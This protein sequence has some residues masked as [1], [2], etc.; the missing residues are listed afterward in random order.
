MQK[1]GTIPEHGAFTQLHTPNPP[2][3]KYS[4]SQNRN[5]KFTTKVNKA[6][7]GSAKSSRIPTT[8]IYTWCSYNSRKLQLFVVS[9]N[10]SPDRGVPD[11][12]TSEGAQ[13]EKHNT[14]E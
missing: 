5:I 6:N 8:N 11:H 1:A 9:V 3:L 13:S 2:T 14:N 12:A 7:G 4:K 10:A